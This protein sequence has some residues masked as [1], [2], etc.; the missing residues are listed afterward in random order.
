[1]PKDLD[2][3]AASVSDLN[4]ILNKWGNITA[5]LWQ[6]VDKI[7][8]HSPDRL[9]ESYQCGKDWQKSLVT[10]SGF[11]SHPKSYIVSYENGKIRRLWEIRVAL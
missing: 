7:Y 4:D 6:L 5:T 8:W 9:F 11:C 2:H 1:V 3:L 10:V